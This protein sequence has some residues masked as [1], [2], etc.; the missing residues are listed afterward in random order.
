M[1]NKIL[2]LLDFGSSCT[3]LGLSAVDL[4]K[5]LR[6]QFKG[7]D[8]KRVTTATGQTTRIK[9]ELE[10]PITLRHQVKYLKVYALPT[11][12]LPIYTRSGFFIYVWNRWESVER[13]MVFAKM[14]KTS[15]LEE[16][17]LTAV[18]KTLSPNMAGSREGTRIRRSRKGWPICCGLVEISSARGRRL[19]DFL[20]SQIIGDP[21]KA[22]IT[23]LTEHRIDVGNHTPIKAILSVDKVLEAGIIES[24]KSEWS[25]PVVMIKKSNGT[26]RF[27][28]DFRKLNNASKKDAYLL[29]DM[30]LILDKSRAA[31][32]ISTIDLSQVYFQIPL[33]S[34][35]R[36][37]IAF[38]GK[39][40]FHFTRMSFGLTGAPATFQRWLDRLIGLEMEPHAFT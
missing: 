26:Y 38:T 32:Y 36:E 24:S 3:F 28:L 8:G 37:L 11:L 29:H 7:L 19:K 15:Q 21:S 16:R 25:S 18:K 31:R 14:E 9:G 4:V 17:P 34:K 12:A 22:G 1:R 20:A 5:T 10:V 35:N 6:M 33:E 27:F 39:G 23:N 30:N 13:R 40:L 2:A